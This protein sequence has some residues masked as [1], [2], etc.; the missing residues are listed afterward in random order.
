MIESR[1]IIPSDPVDLQAASV[2]FHGTLRG[3]QLEVEP[4]DG[5]AAWQGLVDHSHL[6]LNWISRGTRLT[7]T[8]I[9]S[10]VGGFD[11]AV[12]V[13]GNQVASAS[14]QIANTKA[15]DI[16]AAKSRVAQTAAAARLA[17]HTTAVARA[18]AGRQS[19]AKAA[20]HRQRP[21]K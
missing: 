8:F 7:T 19:A 15:A 1:W 3:S 16:A 11:T 13:L 4:A 6:T 20:A 18:A 9:A 10:N 14:A 12:Q 2:D 21:H 5:S 17:A